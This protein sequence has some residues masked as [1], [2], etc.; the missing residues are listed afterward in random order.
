MN[1]LFFSMNFLPQDRGGLEK[2]LY[3]ILQYLKTRHKMVLLLPSHHHVT[4]SNVKIYNFFRPKSTFLQALTGY[5]ALLLQ[6]P[7]IILKEQ[8]DVISTFN[9]SISSAIVFFIGKLFRKRTIINI[10]GYFEPSPLPDRISCDL[11]LLFSDKIIVN[12]KDLLPRIFQLSFLPRAFEG[13]KWMFIPNG[14]NSAIWTHP[15]E[16]EI[17]DIAFLAN[18]QQEL[19]IIGK[20]FNYFVKACHALYGDGAFQTKKV[21]VIGQCDMKLI[22][23]L[24]GDFNESYFEFVGEVSDKHLIMK[25]LSRAKIF[26]HS[27]TNEGMSNAL[28]QAMALG[29]PC[30]ATRVGAIPELIEEGKSGIIVPPKDIPALADAMKILLNNANLR[31]ELGNAARI[32]MQNKFSWKK[33][34]RYM[35][36]FFQK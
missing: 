19:R 31:S 23:K 3:I 30:I 35:E 7:R 15:K 4:I 17:Y 9:Y 2:N 20:G 33:T 13:N 10:W 25:Y 8:I 5:L 6:L 29:R 24:C 14:I 12:S 26:V 36:Y 28:M 11:N 1:I 27:S 22:K 16:E 34:I 21:V 32:R 18:L